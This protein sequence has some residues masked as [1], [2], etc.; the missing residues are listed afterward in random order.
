MESKS[1][2]LS[3]AKCDEFEQTGEYNA[4]NN[5]PSYLGISS[6]TIDH[7]QTGIR[8]IMHKQHNAWLCRH[9]FESVSGI[10]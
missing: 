10:S 5:E 9:I 7:N 8:C 2:A 1:D 4:D 3:G 6:A